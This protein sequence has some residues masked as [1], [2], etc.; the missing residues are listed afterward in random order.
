[1]TIFFWHCFRNFGSKHKIWPWKDTLPLLKN[2]KF[3]KMWKC[4]W[5]HSFGIRI[6]LNFL[7]LRIK[8]NLGMYQ[9]IDSLNLRRPL[10]L[11]IKNKKKSQL[12]FV[13]TSKFLVCLIRQ[14]MYFIFFFTEDCFFVCSS[15]FMLIQSLFVFSV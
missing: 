14:N 12:S 4:I 7:C 3:D 15:F 5:F 9:K 1:M 8:R 13:L 2:G 6:P 11:H 10:I